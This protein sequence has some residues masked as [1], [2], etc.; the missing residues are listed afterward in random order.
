M[1]GSRRRCRRKIH[2]RRDCVCFVVLLVKLSDHDPIL[3]LIIQFVCLPGRV[4]GLRERYS[5]KS[6]SL[7]M[8][9]PAVL[10]CCETSSYRCTVFSLNAETES[11]LLLAA[12]CQRYDSISETTPC[13]QC[14]WGEKQ[15]FRA[16]PL[17]FAGLLQK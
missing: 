12:D 16:S 10:K 17:W 6:K 11:M 2:A 1:F 3:L 8:T 5:C 9:P 13:L 15:L 14:K 7:V 4:A